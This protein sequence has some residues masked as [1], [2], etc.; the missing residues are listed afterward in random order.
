MTYKATIQQQLTEIDAKI[1]EMR[2]KLFKAECTAMF[3]V[4]K[5]ELHAN[6]RFFHRAQSAYGQAFDAWRVIVGTL[7]SLQ[8][9]HG[10]LCNAL[11]QQI[12]GV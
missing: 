7:N 2:E 5:V 1:V 8:S 4:L 12:R 11:D 3:A 10:E 9:E 6:D